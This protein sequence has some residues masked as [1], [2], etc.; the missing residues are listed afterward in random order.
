MATDADPAQRSPAEAVRLV[1]EAV[2]S[3]PFDGMMI[4]TLGVA[5]YRAGKFTEAIERLERS[6]E[7]RGFNKED[8]FFLAMAYARLGRGDKAREIYLRA[9]QALREEHGSMDREAFRF[10]EEAAAVLEVAGEAVTAGASP[11]TPDPSP[12]RG[13]GDRKNAGLSP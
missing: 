10:R 2:K 12:R 9:D 5:F 1:E 8:G 13:E 6:I 3:R 4:S 7:I 11:L